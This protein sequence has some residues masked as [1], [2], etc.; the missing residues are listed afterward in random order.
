MLG[1]RTQ[2]QMFETIAVIFIFFILVLL[3]FVFYANLLR[4]N[5]EVEREES[6]QLNSIE[7]A[8]RA[9][10][11]PELQCSE[12]NIVSDNC[13]DILKLEVAQDIIRD[14]QFHYYDKL[15]FSK[16]N[17]VEIYPENEEWLLYDLSLDEYTSKVVTNI[18][19]SLYDPIKNDNRFGVM[20]VELYLK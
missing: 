20:R 7:V 11:L 10:F 18:P 2:I 19:I 1:K 17:I 15:L 13:I 9:S 6:I 4:G 5:I 3:G 8:Q 16:I 14:N 12:E